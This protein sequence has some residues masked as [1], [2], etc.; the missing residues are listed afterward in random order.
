[1]E[2]TGELECARLILNG[3]LEVMQAIPRMGVA[4][5]GIADVEVLARLGRR[6]E[7]L[8]SLR[9]AIDDGYRGFWWA[10]GLK[11]PHTESLHDDPE[12]IAMMQE[13]KEDMA[14]QLARVRAM[15]ASGELPQIP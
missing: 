14:R 6:D 7:A 4:G 10:Q 5:Y 3:A 1:L 9:R 15:Q 8:A 13:I 11:S 2:K 12:F